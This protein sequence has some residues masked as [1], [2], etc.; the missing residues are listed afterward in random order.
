MITQLIATFRPLRLALALAAG[1]LALPA[2]AA[3]VTF[4]YGGVQLAN[5]RSQTI[6]VNGDGT[7]DLRISDY[8]DQ[9]FAASDSAIQAWGL[10]TAQITGGA[11]LEA[12][13]LIDAS[14]SWMSYSRLSYRYINTANS[15]LSKYTGAWVQ[16]GATVSGYLG[17]NFNLA[18]GIHYGWFSLTVDGDGWV[19]L[20]TL[21]W[22]DVAGVAIVAGSTES[23]ALPAVPLPAAAG[24]LFT[25][26][27]ALGGTAGLRRRRN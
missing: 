17:F 7:A 9:R 15:A 14:E 11:A 3:V 5:N 13:D 8:F 24:L 19:Q 10:G 20:G 25:A 23:Q 18:D 27:A 16:S 4:D 26:L 21:G 2:T 6:D 22:E 1:T 12:G